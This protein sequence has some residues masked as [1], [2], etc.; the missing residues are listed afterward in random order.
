MSNG[1]NPMSAKQIIGKSVTKALTAS[2]FSFLLSSQVPPSFNSM[3]AYAATTPGMPLP[4]A[5]YTSLGDLRMCRVLNGMWQ[6]SGA[7]G[8]ESSRAESVA[9]MTKCAYEGFTTFDAADIYGPA[10][11][12]IGA[13]SQGTTSSAISKDCQFFTKWVPRPTEITQSITNAA[14]DHSLMRMKKEQIDLL[15][16]H[17]WDYENKYYYNAMSSLMH[18]RDSATPKI[19]NIG[20]TNFDTKH[21]V[22][23][24]EQ[25]APIVSN[26]VSFSI[27]D[28]RPLKLMVPACL[29]KNVKLLCYGEIL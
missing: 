1:I 14:I 28:S 29:E 27:L 18:L 10:E 2:S 17:W 9:A 23:L 13:F 22:D 19:K 7:H 12:Y 20:L 3:R 8:Y 25:D 21:M 5:A 11:D 6:V 4:D 24:I 15:Q 16:F 26:Q